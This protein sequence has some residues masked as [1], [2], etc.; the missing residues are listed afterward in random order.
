L[1]RTFEWA[2][3]LGEAYLADLAAVMDAV[4]RLRRRAQSAGRLVTTPQEIVRT[5]QIVDRL[6]QQQKLV[7]R[8]SRNVSHA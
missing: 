3:Q 4:Q 8:E 2:E 6:R 5:E 7:A 1:T